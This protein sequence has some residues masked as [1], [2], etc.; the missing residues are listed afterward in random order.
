MT[1]TQL[2]ISTATFQQAI[3]LLRG[4]HRLLALGTETLPA[5]LT[6]D[7]ELDAIVDEAICTLTEKRHMFQ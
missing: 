3:W 5:A 1:I 4:T 6:G 7:L 2:N